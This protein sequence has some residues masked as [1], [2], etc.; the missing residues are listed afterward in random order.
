MLFG[1][2]ASLIHIIFGLSGQISN[3]GFDIH[4]TVN[5]IAW[6]KIRYYI[7]QCSS[8]TALSCLV[9]SAIDRFFSTC[10]QIK[11]RHLNSV[12]TARQICLYIIIF[13]M[14]ETIPILIHQKP[15]IEL[16]LGKRLCLNSSMI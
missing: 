2:I 13:W 4:W 9:L 3:E 10:H 15:T 8:L 14:L 11:W 16:S 12:N 6:C 5:S 7:A 1:S